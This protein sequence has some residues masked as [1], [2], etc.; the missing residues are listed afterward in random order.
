M[1]VLKITGW[2]WGVGGSA[3]L[4][5]VA[6]LPRVLQSWYTECA[7]QGMRRAS[8]AL[9]RAAASG[10]GGVEKHRLGVGCGWLG[11]AAGSV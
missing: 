11:S 4:W 3:E 6:S 5:A 8:L 9:I 7:L 1:V 10:L 2:G